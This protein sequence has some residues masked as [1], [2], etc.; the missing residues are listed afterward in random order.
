MFRPPVACEDGLW[1]AGSMAMSVS[2]SSAPALLYVVIRKITARVVVVPPGLLCAASQGLP[3]CFSFSSA[4][5]VA[6]AVAPVICSVDRPF[7][8][9]VFGLTT[10]LRFRATLAFF[11]CSTIF[12]KAPLSC[13]MCWLWVCLFTFPS[14]RGCCLFPELSMFVAPSCYEYVGRCIFYFRYFVLHHRE[15]RKALQQMNELYTER[16]GVV[17]VVD[18]SFG[19]L[20]TLSALS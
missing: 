3:D 18:V 17:V 11:T 6:D 9:L 13:S 5:T 10:L 12:T 7:L 4:C 20:V 8:F 14:C 19:V 16:A 1:G 15:T 2:T